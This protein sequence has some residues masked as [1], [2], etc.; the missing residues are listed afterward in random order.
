MTLYLSRAIHGAN[1]PAPPIPPP[2]L[3]PSVVSD[4]ETTGITG[5]SDLTEENEQRLKRNQM[6]AEYETWRA[7]RR[8]VVHTL[9]VS[10]KHSKHAEGTVRNFRNGIYFP[11]VDFHVGSITD[12]L[13]GRLA[14]SEGPFL[15]HA[16]LDLPG[17]HDYLNILAEALRPNGSLI[18]FCPSITQIYKCTALVKAH[19]LPFMLETALEVGAGIGVGGREWDVRAVRPRS[20]IKAEAEARDQTALEE[21]TS[22]DGNDTAEQTEIEGPAQ[23]DSGYEMVCRPKVGVRVR[24]GG[25]VGLWRRMESY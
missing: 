10:K 9:D 21:V 23:S 13:S 6:Q 2:T 22:E 7:Q 25:F 15:S 20:L 8:A 4:E 1:P 19:K 24:G 16:I 5:T 11:N 17:T 14:K 3:T 12:Y 18:T